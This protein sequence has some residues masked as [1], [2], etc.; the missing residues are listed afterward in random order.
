MPH[1]EFFCHACNRSFS[2]TL[3]PVENNEGKVVCTRCGSEEVEQ[4]GP[5]WSPPSRVRKQLDTFDSAL[6]HRCFSKAKARRTPSIGG[7]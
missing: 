1:S 6:K 2:K 4:R 3:T 7:N 5:T